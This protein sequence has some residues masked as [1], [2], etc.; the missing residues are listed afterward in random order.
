[1]K[2]KKGSK[3][4]SKWWIGIVPYVYEDGNNYFAFK[5]NQKERITE[6]FF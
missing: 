4:K 2:L 1:M 6:S 3:E 5:D